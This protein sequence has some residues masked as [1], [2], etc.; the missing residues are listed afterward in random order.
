MK[1]IYWD[2]FISSEGNTKALIIYKPILRG[3]PP[4]CIP[5]TASTMSTME[6]MPTA[7]SV[8]ETDTTNTIQT[9]T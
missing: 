1:C 7:L 4:P 3:F 5:P 9:E 6:T 8:Q 2:F